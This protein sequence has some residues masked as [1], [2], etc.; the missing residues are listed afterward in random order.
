MVT[1]DPN[2]AINYLKVLRIA[3]KGLTGKAKRLISYLSGGKS[4]GVSA[5]YGSARGERAHRIRKTA[6]ISCG[7]E[8]VLNRNSE[9]I[10]NDLGKNGLMTLPLAC[11]TRSNI[12]STAC[13]HLDEATFVWAHPRSFNVTSNTN[14]DFAPHGRIFTAHSFEVIPADHFLEHCH[15]CRK[16]T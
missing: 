9:F 16:V 10:G 8:Y 4:D 7:D 13:L 3:L 1:L 14:A 2:D 12:N 6:G 15:R 11:E 5:H